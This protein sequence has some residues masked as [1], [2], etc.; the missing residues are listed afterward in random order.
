MTLGAGVNRLITIATETNIGVQASGPG[1]AL[2]RAQ[3][4]MNPDVSPILSPEI[5][6]SQQVRDN[7]NGPRRSRITHNT[8]LAPGAYKDFF[9]GLLRGTWTSGVAK[10]GVTDSVATSVNGN[11]V[12]TSAT[13]AWLVANLKKGD[14]VRITGATGGGVAANNV[15]MRI[16]GVTATVLTLQPLSTIT[17]PTW[18]SGQTIA[19]TVVGKKLMIPATGQVRRSYSIE[20]WYADNS[21][22]H[23]GLGGRMQ[24]ISL[25]FSPTSMVQLQAT[26]LGLDFIKGNSRIYASPTAISTASGVT[27]VAGRVGYQ[28][29]NLGYIT[30][31]NLQLVANLAA[32][33]VIGSPIAPEVF[34]GTFMARGSLNALFEDDTMMAD[35]LAENDVEIS[36]YATTGPAANADF[37]SVYM[38]RCRLGSP[39][40]NDTDLAL[41]RQIPFQALEQ[42]TSTGFDLSTIVI[43]DSLA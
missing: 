9:D 29:A 35:F 23:L 8:V 19:V 26:L 40:M 18:A 36:S 27:M 17:I 1:Q 20:H 7:R 41:Q 14:V 34:Q 3:A 22:S 32:D 39:D 28:G 5:L 12:L 16:V 6:P 11:L 24:Q 37:V 21:I 33:P 4:T 2:R 42:L 30:G 31:M 13:A 38:S 43:Q 25:G 10:T 15:N